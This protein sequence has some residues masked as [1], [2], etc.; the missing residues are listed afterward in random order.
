MN[1]FTLLTENSRLKMEVEDL[2]AALNR[3]LRLKQEFEQVDRLRGQFKL[4]TMEARLLLALYDAY[5]RT[6]TKES[7]MDL[8][9]ADADDEPGVK[10]LEVRVCNIRKKVG[11]LAILNVYGVGWCLTEFGKNIIEGESNG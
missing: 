2:Q 3:E 5:P 8:F 7:L 1:S 11:K 9:Y 4:T 10:I 6:V